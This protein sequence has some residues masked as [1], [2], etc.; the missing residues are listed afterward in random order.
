MTG[1]ECQASR[2]WYVAVQRRFGD[3]QRRT[4]GIEGG[5]RLVEEKF[6]GKDNSWM[7]GAQYWATA[8]STTGTSGRKTGLRPLLN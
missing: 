4:D 3:F 8:L 7:V 5:D 6:G 1:K 2:E